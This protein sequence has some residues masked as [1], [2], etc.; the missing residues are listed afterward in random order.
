MTTPTMSDTMSV[1]GSITTPPA[2]MSMPSA[3]SPLFSTADT[4]MPATKPM[5][6]ATIPMTSAS[7]IMLPSTWRRLAPMARSRAVSRWRW[8]TMIENVL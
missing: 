3:D 5:I 6:D 2:G 1:R 8:A 7:T 4:P